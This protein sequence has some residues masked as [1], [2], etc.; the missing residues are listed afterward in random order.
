M[1][2]VVIQAGGRSDRMG[3]NKALMPFLGEPLV[4]RLTNRFLP[5]ANELIINTNSPDLFEF[6]LLPKV[7]DKISGV[8]ALGGLYTALDAASYPF[9][10]VI[11]CDMPFA[12]VEITRHQ[13]KLIQSLAVDVV[14]PHTED[15]YEPL[16]AV[17][18]KETCLP[19]IEKAIQTGKRRMI[20]WFNHLK[21]L[22]VPATELNSI[23][24]AKHAF[25][26]INTP[27]EFSAAEAIALENQV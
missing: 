4:V 12:S 16:H 25:I 26:N 2:T 13:L 6:I 10:A 23:D 3:Q 20:S 27:E 21:I 5:I 15:G 7:V 24:G 8:G 14:I 11:A 17:Y 18:R 22:E 1:L 19:E 9:V